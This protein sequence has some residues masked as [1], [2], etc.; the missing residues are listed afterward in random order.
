MK[1]FRH[2]NHFSS[3][4]FPKRSVF[5]G[6]KPKGQ[7]GEAAKPPVEA[8][9]S[10]SQEYKDKFKDYVDKSDLDQKQMDD[11][12]KLDPAAA[13]QEA[14]VAIQREASKKEAL[15]LD[16]KPLPEITKALEEAKKQ[17]AETRDKITHL[18]EYSKFKAEVS[19]LDVD[20]EK[21][22]K[23]LKSKLEGY[24]PESAAELLQTRKSMEGLL[25]KYEKL[26]GATN[27]TGD[28]KKGLKLGDSIGDLKAD[29]PEFEQYAN[30]YFT[31]EWERVNKIV[32]YKETETKAATD[33]KDQEMA[34]LRNETNF[35]TDTVKLP[36]NFAQ[37][38]G[39][40]KVRS[41]NAYFAQ[42]NAMRADIVG[43]K[44]ECS[45]LLAAI[46]ADPLVGKDVKSTIKS[47]LRTVMATLDAELKKV[48]DRVAKMGKDGVAVSEDYLKEKKDAEKKVL[49][50]ALKESAQVQQKLMSA[51]LVVDP[52]ISAM[53]EGPEKEAAKKAAYSK[54][55]PQIYSQ[56]NIAYNKYLEQKQYYDSLSG[57]K[58]DKTFLPASLDYGDANK[59]LK[60]KLG[61]QDPHTLDPDSPNGPKPP[62]GVK[63]G[64]PE[65]KA[66]YNK[67][68]S[69]YIDRWYA[70]AAKENVWPPK[71]EGEKK[72]ETDKSN[73]ETAKTT[74]S[75]KLAELKKA[76]DANMKGSTLNGQLETRMKDAEKLMATDPAKA[77]TEFDSIATD[78]GK[79]LDKVNAYAK[80]GPI[81][82]NG[83]ERKT[84]LSDPAAGLKEGETKEFRTTF[85][86]DG[87][88]QTV[89]VSATGIK[90]GVSF[91]GRN[92]MFS[93]Y[94][95]GQADLPQL[96]SAIEGALQKQ[97]YEKV[98]GTGGAA[99][100]GGAEPMRVASN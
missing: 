29:I 38:E 23:D 77:K 48:N 9:K 92:Y 83:Q 79:L 72:M 43:A 13:A 81:Y 45:K 8:I 58:A 80:L 75:G 44:D 100:Q 47:N 46:D 14:L 74:A 4:P 15:G 94:T 21:L 1:I 19:V 63:E 17:I 11:L 96:Y 34:L 54:I 50:D 60:A 90:G 61:D 84:L 82:E 67:Q 2:Q 30:D 73:A 10:K 37:Q 28:E 5:N 95:G 97:R 87:K 88:P 18:V 16:N 55:D 49:D 26:N 27:I 57:I 68:K 89:S 51:I 59:A 86:I 69:R 99:P 56:A 98:F 41:G 66:W 53:P 93:G 3:G 20:K 35:K 62:E 40:E 64:T 7:E 91:E 65:Y 25:A 42:L 33:Q 78:A 32:G 85:Y 36:E 6:E 12:K 71:T 24:K 39:V 70:D 22:Y 76:L 52:S 31:T